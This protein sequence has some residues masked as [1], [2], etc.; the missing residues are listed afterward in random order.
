MSEDYK[1]IF[2]TAT[3]NK[4]K[5]GD[6]INSVLVLMKDVRDFQEKIESCAEAQAIAENKAKIE[7]F[8][9]Y[10]EDMYE[11]LLGM[12]SEGVR[13]VRQKED[14]AEELPP[15]VMLNTPTIPKM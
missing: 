5:K 8:Q 10:V 2:V 6:G 13:V 9:S 4:A 7:E 3:D 15:P 14:V 11:V 1:D 12:A